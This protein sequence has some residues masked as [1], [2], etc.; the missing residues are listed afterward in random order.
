MTEYESEDRRVTSEKRLAK[1]EVDV[2]IIKA[3]LSERCVARESRL[4]D[5]ETRVG[6][7]ER[8]YQKR[9]GG[10][11]VLSAAVTIAGAIGGLIVKY[12]TRG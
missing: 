8:D 5:L 7:L 1:I 11:V 12:F 9:L 4:S 10:L 6:P 3:M 2:A